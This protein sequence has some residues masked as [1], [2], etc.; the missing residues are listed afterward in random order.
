MKTARAL[1]RSS[2]PIRTRTDQATDAEVPQRKFLRLADLELKRALCSR[3]RDAA[4]N[5]V[6]EM[7]QQLA[8]ITQEQARMLRTVD[9][10]TQLAAFG[11]STQRGSGFTLKYGSR[12]HVNG[13]DGREERT[14]TP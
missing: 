12:L 9:A 4:A 11:D 10:A 14:H 3:V 6:A 13:S 5:R 7:D 1:R 2:R 8:E